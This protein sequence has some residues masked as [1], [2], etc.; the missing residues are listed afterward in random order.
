[1]PPATCA[2]PAE[3]C[4]AHRTLP[5][6]QPRPLTVQPHSARPQPCR[7]GSELPLEIERLWSTLAGNRRNIIPVLDFLVSLGMHVAF[8]VGRLQTAA[9]A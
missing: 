2:F 8:Q 5:Q 7:H 6:P 3:G 1:M 4:A 9:A